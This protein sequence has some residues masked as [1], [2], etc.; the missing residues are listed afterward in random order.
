[1]YCFALALYARLLLLMHTVIALVQA[2]IT[3]GVNYLRAYI[4]LIDR[5]ALA[6]AHALRQFTR[7]NRG[8]VGIGGIIGLFISMLVVFYIVGALINPVE[9]AVSTV[10]NSLQNSTFT[11]V[12]NI[13]DLPKVSYLIGLITVIVGLIYIAWGRE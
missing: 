7:D 8:Q 5:L 10:T 3:S 13:K 1:M 4:K 6:Y 12:Q 9:S 2:A 11:E